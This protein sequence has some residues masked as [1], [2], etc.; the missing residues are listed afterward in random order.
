MTVFARPRQAPLPIILKM[1]TFILISSILVYFIPYTSGQPI[2]GAFDSFSYAYLVNLDKEFAINFQRFLMLYPQGLEASAQF[3]YAALLHVA[4]AA[5]IVVYM[6]KTQHSHL[7][8]ICALALLIPESTIFLACPSKEALGICAVLALIAFHLRFSGKWDLPSF[9]IVLYA[10]IIAEVSRP[11]FSIVFVVAFIFSLL[12]YFSAR[13]R[14]NLLLSSAILFVFILILLLGPYYTSF[15]QTYQEARSFLLFFEADL[16]SQSRFKSVIR[17]VFVVAFE[18]DKPSLIFVFIAMFF[19]FIKAIIYFFAIPLVS[20]P[21]KLSMPFFTWAL[22]WQ[23]AS[24][25]TSIYCAIMLFR[26]YY[27][28]GFSSQRARAVLLLAISLLFLIAISTAIFHVRYRA[29]AMVAF[30]AAFSIARYDL[31][32]IRPPPWIPMQ[33]V[34]IAAACFALFQTQ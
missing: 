18:S 4:V 22:S 2:N 16:G 30:V 8:S 6:A 9:V 31:G 28:G 27:V 14:I 5:P 13:V 20:L 12:P 17:G 11:N 19:A 25:I 21:E 7:M 33:A 10:M 15:T 24:T 32:S 29:P 3:P 26:T 1:V 34:Y 23:I